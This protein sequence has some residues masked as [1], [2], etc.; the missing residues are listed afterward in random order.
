MKSSVMQ[1]WKSI[2]AR[3][4]G[5]AGE[6]SVPAD[7]QE[8]IDI[9]MAGSEA[10][11]FEAEP[12]STAGRLLIYKQTAMNLAAERAKEAGVEFNANLFAKYFHQYVGIQMREENTLP[13]LR[14]TTALVEADALA[15]ACCGD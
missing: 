13:P 4:D 8:L 5:T 7:V 1:T 9:A 12:E 11:A 15:S 2:Q 3:K 10:M 6:I 14:Y